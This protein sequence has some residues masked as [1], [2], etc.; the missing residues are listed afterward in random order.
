VIQ[1]NPIF[2]HEKNFYESKNIDAFFQYTTGV[3]NMIQFIVW[4]RNAE[5]LNNELPKPQ[6]GAKNLSIKIHMF[7]L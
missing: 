6:F 3:R 7:S 4:S 5:K 1:I 2:L